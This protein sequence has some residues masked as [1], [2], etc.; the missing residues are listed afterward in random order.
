[1]KREYGPMGVGSGTHTEQAGKTMIAYEKQIMDAKPDFTVVVGDVNS[2][3]AASLAS[4]SRSV[5]SSS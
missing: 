2:T 1:M 3:A 4:S 5:T